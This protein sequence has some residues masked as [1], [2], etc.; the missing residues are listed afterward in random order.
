M[1][2]YKVIQDIEAEDKIVGFLTLK[3][4]I[5]ALIAAALAYIN[6]RLLMASVV[7]PLRFVFILILLFP[8]FLFG[9]LA[10]PLGRDQ[11]T[12]VWILSHVKFFLNPRK[13]IWDQSGLQELVTVTAPKKIEKDYTKGLSQNDVQSRLKALATTLDSRG[14]AVK[15]VAVNL[16]ANPSYLDVEPEDSDRLVSAASVAQDQTADIHAADDIM[17]E[18]NNPTAQHFE[19]LMQQADARR[20]V[21]VLSKV[22]RAREEKNKIPELADSTFLDQANSSGETKFVGHKIIAP[23]SHNDSEES[24]NET[25]GQDERDY[26][27]RLHQKAEAVHAKSVGFKPKTHKKEAEKQDTAAPL[28][29]QPAAVTAPPQNVKLKELIDVAKDDK[30]S[31]LAK[32]AS[33]DKYQIKQSGPNEVE[34]DLH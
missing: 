1:A 22:N 13:R 20:K 3:T 21:N 14:W 15:N 31:T 33:R 11:P 29:E 10:A 7:G 9:L 18:Q 8:M 32:E 5:Y 17:D 12:E 26:L 23:G 6:V 28:Q 19:A 24:S 27:D 2:V 34:I 16:S 4:F 25:L 30:L